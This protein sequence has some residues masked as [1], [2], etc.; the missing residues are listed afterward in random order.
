M[1][2]HAEKW[3]VKST[4]ANVQLGHVFPSLRTCRT[5][6]F[7]FTTDS[8]IALDNTCLQQKQ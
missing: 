2:D 5:L 1:G 8:S 4:K 6:H 7:V 3:L